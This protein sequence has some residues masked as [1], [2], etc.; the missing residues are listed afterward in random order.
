VGLGSGVDITEEGLYTADHMEMR[1]A[2]S[3]LIE[4]EINPYVDEWEKAQMFP[5]KKVCYKG[6]W[7]QLGCAVCG[8][9]VCLPVCGLYLI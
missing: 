6:V 4:K 3:K 1:N 5:A 2:L 8:C 9:G 7:P